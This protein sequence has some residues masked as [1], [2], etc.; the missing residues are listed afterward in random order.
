LRR[1]FSPFKVDA[2]SPPLGVTALSILQKCLTVGEGTGAPRQRERVAF[3][4]NIDGAPR[5]RGLFRGHHFGARR[6]QPIRS[7]HT[8]FPQYKKV[9]SVKP[10]AR[11]ATA[12]D[13]PLT[14]ALG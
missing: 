11:E 7:L 5:G 8:G 14:V 12:G 6:V 10:V 3:C 13:G 1:Q 4:R 2:K 9:E